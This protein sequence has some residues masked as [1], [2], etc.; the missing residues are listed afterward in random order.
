MRAPKYITAIYLFI[1]VGGL[2]AFFA[3][4]IWVW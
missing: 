4:A 1:V 2:L 3:L